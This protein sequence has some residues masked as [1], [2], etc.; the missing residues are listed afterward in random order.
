VNQGDVDTMVHTIFGTEYGDAN[1]DQSV[2]AL[3]FN[4]L[5]SPFGFKAPAGDVALGTTVPEPANLLGLLLF[6]GVFAR[7]RRAAIFA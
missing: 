1:L 2:N 5:A 7:R 6:G 4:A 3:D